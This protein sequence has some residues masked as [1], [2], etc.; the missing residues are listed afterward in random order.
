MTHYAVNTVGAVLAHVVAEG[1]GVGKDH[2]SVYDYGRI[3]Y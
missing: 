2:I 1:E 3:Y